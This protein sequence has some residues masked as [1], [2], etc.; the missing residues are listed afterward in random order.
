[1]IGHI[2]PGVNVYSTLAKGGDVCAGREGEAAAVP[3]DGLAQTLVK[4]AD[5]VKLAVFAHTHFRRGTRGPAP[6]KSPP[7]EPGWAIVAVGVA[8]CVGE[9]VVVIAVGCRPDATVRR[10]P[11]GVQALLQRLRPYRHLSV[12]KRVAGRRKILE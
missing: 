3:S 10:T 8:Q 2:P 11:S 7:D 12:S 5:V 4:H 6:M 9:S 1:M